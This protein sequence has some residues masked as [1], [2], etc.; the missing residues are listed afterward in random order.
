MERGLH[1]HDISGK[2]PSCIQKIIKTILKPFI[3]LK[4][5][6]D[7]NWW[8]ERI[9]NKTGIYDIAKESKIRLWALGLTGWRYWTYQIGGGILFVIIIETILNQIN[10]SILPWR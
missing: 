3:M 9:A 6:L 8:A 7:G 2:K 4:N 1:D 10:L 5:I